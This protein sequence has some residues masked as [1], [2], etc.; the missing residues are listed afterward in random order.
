MENQRHAWRHE[1]M[2]VYVMRPSVRILHRASTRPSPADLA[3]CMRLTLWW[4]LSHRLQAA[5]HS[6]HPRHV[7]SGDAYPDRCLSCTGRNH[8]RDRCWILPH[9]DATVSQTEEYAYEWYAQNIQYLSLYPAGPPGH[10]VM[11]PLLRHV[12]HAPLLSIDGELDN[13]R[14]RATHSVDRIRRRHITPRRNPES[15]RQEKNR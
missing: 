14:N 9:A 15:C 7:R 3:L 8:G 5:R 1:H 4:L 13:Y 12:G 10:H 6:S 11:S 2:M